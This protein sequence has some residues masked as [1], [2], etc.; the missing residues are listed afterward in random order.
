MNARTLLI[1]LAGIATGLLVSSVD[2]R[3]PRE[4]LGTARDGC[5]FD[6]VVGPPLSDQEAEGL[7]YMRE[8]E[9]LARDVYVTLFDL[10]AVPAFSRISE[11]EQRHMDALG[12]LIVRYDLEDPVIDDAIGVFTDPDFEDLYDELVE[13]GATSEIDALKVGALIEELDIADLR[14][15]LAQTDHPDLQRVYENLMRGSRNHLRAFAQLIA[16]EGETYEAQHLTQEEF[17]EIAASPVERGK[18]RRDGRCRGDGF[19]KGGSDSPDL[20]QG[21]RARRGRCL[22]RR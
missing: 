22:G 11:A 7:L 4:P 10:W 8:E 12:R 9:K 19:R 3:G 13:A 14:E 1:P 15:E 20:Q 21:P 6:A 16:A 2:A 18:G 17:D 5:L